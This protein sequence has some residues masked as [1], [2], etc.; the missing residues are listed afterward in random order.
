M[1]ASAMR[2]HASTR[3]AG[4]RHDRGND[5]A[6][7]TDTLITTTRPPSAHGA[8]DYIYV[9]ISTQRTPEEHA[10]RLDRNSRCSIQ[11]PVA[12]RPTGTQRAMASR[13]TPATTQKQK[14]GTG[15]PG[16]FNGASF[17][18]RLAAA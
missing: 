5:G 8:T 17:Y 15:Q 10:R 13:Q 1:P 18:S 11:P 3:L 2:P 7:G 16:I 4:T 14:A 12:C 6:H 9:K